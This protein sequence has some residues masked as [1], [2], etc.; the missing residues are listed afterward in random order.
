MDADTGNSIVIVDLDIK[1]YHAKFFSFQG[2]SN[3]AQQI[4]H[5][6]VKCFNIW[7]YRYKL[8]GLEQNVG[9]KHLEDE[10]PNQ[11]TQFIYEVA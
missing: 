1:V 8:S 3:A 6:V 5:A 7:I 2:Y 9:V 11:A 4:A 10:S